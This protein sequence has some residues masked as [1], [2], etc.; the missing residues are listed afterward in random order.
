MRKK[1]VVKLPV[2]LAP[3][4]ARPQGATVKTNKQR[5]AIPGTAAAR[6][7]RLSLN[8]MIS[9]SRIFAAESRTQRDGFKVKTN[10]AL[11]AFPKRWNLVR[12]L[13]DAESARIARAMAVF[14]GV[15]PL[16]FALARL[17]CADVQ[18]VH[19]SA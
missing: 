7:P 5:A 2:S 17:P 1:G 14:A 9:L 15:S 12:K 10:A 8:E 18:A 13:S 19:R 6:S 4:C 16:L 3:D 11:S